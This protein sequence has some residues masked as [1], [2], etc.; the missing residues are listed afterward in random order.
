MSLKLK[1]KITLD[2][3]VSRIQN[4]HCS[5]DDCDSRNILITL[6]DNGKPY[7]LSQ[8]DILCIKISKPDHT[9]VYMD[10]D[11]AHV[12][13]NED[14]TISLILPEQATCVPGKCDAELKIISE[15]STVTTA[16]FHIIVRK[17]V[18]EDNEIESAVESN[19]I[20]KMVR[21]LA[22][23]SNPHKTDKVQVGLGNVPNVTTND[24]T[25]TYTESS[26]LNTL[27]SGETLSTAFGKIAKAIHTFIEHLT[28][29]ASVLSYGHTR[30]VDSVT[31]TSTDASATP[32]SVKTAYDKAAEVAN[33]L[34]RHNLSEDAHADLR[35]FMET[36]SSRLSAVADSDD[37]TLDQLSEIVAY[38][39]NNKSLIDSITTT[40][41]NVTDIVDNLTSAAADKPLSAR[42]GKTLRD[43]IDTAVNADVSG[44]KGDAEDAYRT[45]YVNLTPA[46]IGLAN[47]DNTHDLDKNVASSKNL[48]LQEDNFRDGADLSNTYPIGETVFFS[49]NPTNRFNGLQFCTVHTIRGYGIGT[50]QF[51]Y[52]YNTNHDKFYFR[53]ALYNTNTWRDWHEIITSANIGQQSVNY[54]NSAENAATAT[55][56]AKLGR[57]GNTGLPMTF[58]WSGQAGQPTWLWGGTDGTN[59]YVY[60]PANFSVKSAT[61]ATSAGTATKATQDGN[62]NNIVNTYFPK[63]G[64]AMSGNLDLE[65]QKWVRS[66]T[67]AGVQTTLLGMNSKNNIHM[68][69]YNGSDASPVFMHAQG[70]QY[71]FYAASFHPSSSNARTLGDTSHLWKTVYAKT[72][73]INTSDRTKKHDICDISE[74]YEQ[75]FLKLQPKSFIFNDGDRVHIGAISQ[76]VEDAMTEL[77]IEPEQFAGFCR[78]VRYKYTEFNEEDGT[79]V[80]SSKVLCTD[81]N[82][83]P[84]YDYSL[85]YQEFIFLT[86]HMTQLLWKKVERI[87]EENRMLKEKFTALEA[88]INALSGS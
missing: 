69:D 31:S 81:E 30:L 13:R 1:Q 74:V 41:I 67:T 42:Q 25:P 26:A 14:G 9:F 47:V 84:I 53:E 35:D 43:L 65:N 54:A 46:N 22:D 82:D 55:T 49:N 33:D 11:D 87:E 59:M 76:D 5:Q 70:V 71:D 83:N 66:K 36:L 63:T 34:D 62:G 44:V 40:K 77:G 37:E 38:I 7:R 52:P 6:S 28:E 23:E 39:K 45:G 12:S 48:S 61:S 85:R 78:D 29:H 57:D 72:G 50:I 60:N 17:S 8:S 3:T 56:A 27:S 15:N 58:H 75:L 32:N 10:D 86:V 4:I 88:R 21:H 16:C 20:E 64:G 24:Q 68:G 79:P 2:F 19:I 73:T 18:L 80:E 51:L